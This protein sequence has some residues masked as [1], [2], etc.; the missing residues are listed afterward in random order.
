MKKQN[1]NKPPEPLLAPD[2]P[3]NAQEFPVVTPSKPLLMLRKSR[4]KQ[5]SKNRRR[6]PDE[7]GR[8]TLEDAYTFT[9][10]LS[11][12]T[13]DLEKAIR[14]AS[15]LLKWASEIGNEN[16]DGFLVLGVAN[17]LD[18]CADQLRYLF[19]SDDIE[20]LGAEP[21]NV[22]ASRSEPDPEKARAIAR[23]TT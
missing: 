12:D 10:N 9:A 1:R 18:A 4:S 14:A 8:L 7:V 15:Y 22:K 21:C 2:L 3:E 23:G 17:A 19:T 16:P 11:K 5:T 6:K 20:R 13:S